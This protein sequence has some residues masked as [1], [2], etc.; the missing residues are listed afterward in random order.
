MR[1]HILSVED[2][3]TEAA[4]VAAVPG[5]YDEL[6]FTYRPLLHVERDA[7]SDQS[8]KSAQNFESVLVAVMQSKLKTWD[9]MDGKGN[10]MPIN[11]ATIKR[12]QPA[13]FD[14]VYTIIAGR[15]PS[16]PDPKNQNPEREKADD[17]VASIVS[18][19]LVGD[20]REEGDRKNSP[21]G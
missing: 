17:V 15:V 18:G 5:L 1:G 8:G 20:I 13:L 14:K 7:V 10:P 4:Y 11:A 21:E 6:R 2:G 19:K 12:L 16:D 3:Y 9:A